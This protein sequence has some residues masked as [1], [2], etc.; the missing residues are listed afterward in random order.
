MSRLVKASA[1]VLLVLTFSAPIAAGAQAPQRQ[2]FS[3]V[4]HGVIYCG[5]FEDDFIDHYSGT[6]VVYFDSSG[7]AVR[8]VFYLEHHSD[9]RNS[10]TGFVLHEHGSFVFTIDLLTGATTTVG[11]Q[12]V[13]TRP[14]YGLVIQDVGRFVFD[15][16]GNLV[17]AAGSQQHSGGDERYCDALS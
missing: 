14:G 11:N 6:E 4:G 8:D 13:L 1:L 3:L 12:E 10:V 2:P 16:N 9:D 15:S 17:F 5:T 7:N